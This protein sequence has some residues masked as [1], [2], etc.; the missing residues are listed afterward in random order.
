MR[1]NPKR[2]GTPRKILAIQLR[3]IGD[4][5]LITP[6]L[7]AIREAW[8]AA[9][10]HLL[11]TGVIPDLFT[12]DPR[13][14]RVWTEPHGRPV[15]WIA[16]KLRR[17]RFD[18][19]FDFQSIPLTAALSLLSGAYAV[20]FQKPH[21]SFC[22]HRSVAIADHA[23]SEYS[24]DHKLD[25]L[26]SLGLKPR[27]TLPRLV[28]PKTPSVLWDELPAGPRVALVPTKRYGNGWPSSAFSQTARLLHRETGAVF[29]IAV[30]PGEEADLERVAAGLGDVPHSVHSFDRLGAFV[31]LLAG[32]DLYLGSDSGPRHIALA[33]GVPTLAHFWTA[34]A[35]HWT[36]P[37][38]ARHFVIWDPK[39]ARGHP[40]RDDLRIIA[41]EPEAVAAAAVDLLRSCSTGST[42]LELR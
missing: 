6:A 1:W 35:T 12:E 27:L 16:L 10:V 32:A 42:D 34:E 8:P 36:P 5:V 13:V 14:E 15:S 31:A 17:E 38:S 39:R 33:F 41:E 4:A 40:V 11:T 26:R 3:R 28:P 23:E 2:D 19:V 24:A 25:L 29:T 21:R 37:G 7:D 9:E 20:G 30:G 22:Y 18:L